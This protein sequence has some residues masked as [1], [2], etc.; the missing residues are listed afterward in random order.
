MKWN[1]SLLNWHDG[2]EEEGWFHWALNISFFTDTRILVQWGD[3]I[4]LVL[5]ITISVAP[6]L[7]LP[8]FVSLS[9]S[10][11]FFFHW[12]TLL[13]MK[14]RKEEQCLTFQGKG[15]PLEDSTRI[16]PCVFFSGCL[17]KQGHDFKDHGQGEQTFHWTHP[18]PHL[19]TEENK[20]P[21]S[22]QIWI[23]DCLPR[24]IPAYQSA[25]SKE[26]NPQLPSLPG[27]HCSLFCSTFSPLSTWII[28]MV[29][30]PKQSESKQAKVKGMPRV[31]LSMI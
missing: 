9:L 21:W 3:L 30:P 26:A 31:F 2:G 14:Y 13:K 7:F 6:L 28:Q 29:W 24:Q 10:L 27:S 11:F 8:Y 12:I 17:E 19:T 25:C 5:E 23:E 4:A 1:E 18:E 20:S 22:R 15:F 16:Y